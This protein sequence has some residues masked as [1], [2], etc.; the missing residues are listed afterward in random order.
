MNGDKEMF[1]KFNRRVTLKK[2]ETV[3]SRGS[4]IKNK[5]LPSRYLLL[6][7]SRSF[8][9]RRSTWSDSS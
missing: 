9:L 5:I 2:L 3:V 8:T 7:A 6:S 1:S 4:R